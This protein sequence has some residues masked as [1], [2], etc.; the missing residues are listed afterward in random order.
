[1]R[2]RNAPAANTAAPPVLAMKLEGF[3]GLKGEKKMMHDDI[4]GNTKSCNPRNASSLAMTAIEPKR[5]RP[6]MI[7]STILVRLLSEILSE[8][9]A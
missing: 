4:M 2:T 5:P 7:A 8:T 6:V 9:T 1:M 3:A